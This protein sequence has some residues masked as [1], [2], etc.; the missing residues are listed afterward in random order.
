MGVG[1]EKWL[2][3]IRKLLG[4]LGTECDVLEKKILF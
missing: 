4:W 2:E 3:T 1:G